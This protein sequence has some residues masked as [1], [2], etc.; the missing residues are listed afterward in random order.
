MYQIIQ[1]EMKEKARRLMAE[2]TEDI[3]KRQAALLERTAEEHNIHVDSE[4]ITKINGM[5]QPTFRK[6]L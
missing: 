1:C 6:T 3:K 4:N 2:K 5:V